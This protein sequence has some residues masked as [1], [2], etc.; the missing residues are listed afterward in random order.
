M[1]GFLQHFFEAF[2]FVR[3]CGIRGPILSGTLRATIHVRGLVL[4]VGL[5]K[6]QY[7]A[8]VYLM[9]PRFDQVIP[10]RNSLASRKEEQRFISV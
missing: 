3:P 8:I 7:S 6:I 2:C 1:H 10:V 4:A 9:T 5:L